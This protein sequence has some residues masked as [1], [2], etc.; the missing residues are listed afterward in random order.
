MSYFQKSKVNELKVKI[1]PGTYITKIKFQ[2]NSRK[3]SMINDIFH[4]KGVPFWKHIFNL[5]IHQ[6]LT[7]LPSNYITFFN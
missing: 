2:K 3:D 6:K 1:S 4:P 7:F 5:K